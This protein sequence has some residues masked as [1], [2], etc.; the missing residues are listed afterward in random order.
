MEKHNNNDNKLYS[1]LLNLYDLLKNND[2]YYLITLHDL[3][4]LVR[5]YVVPSNNINVKSYIS[6]W[7]VNMRNEFNS[8]GMCYKNNLW[9]LCQPS[10]LRILSNETK[11]KNVLD[12]EWKIVRRKK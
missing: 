4:R 2:N 11:I 9:M 8:L 12:N 5:N 1:D 10:T 3:S 7:D 6:Y